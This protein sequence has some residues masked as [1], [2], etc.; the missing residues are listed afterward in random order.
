MPLFAKAEVLAIRK[1]VLA[2]MSR[3]DRDAVRAAARAIAD[4]ADPA[5]A[6]R[7][8]LTSL[9][10]A[11]IK[12]VSAPARELAALRGKARAAY[13]VLER[14]AAT[15]DAIAAIR[16]LGGSDRAPLAR[17][18]KAALVKAR[19]RGHFPEGVWKAPVTTKELIAGGQQGP[20]VS[21]VIFTIRNGRWRTNEKPNFKGPYIVDGDEITFLITSPPEA[22]GQRD[23]VRWNRYRGKLKLEAVALGDESSRVL[24]EA[25]PWEKTG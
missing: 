3:T 17:C 13:P 15:R 22:A 12:L 2:R 16:R 19:S 11:G 25:H 20:L 21:P 14:D 24:Y 23:V 18:P 10:A 5:A 8:D 9:C 7:A 1:D 4:R 6:E